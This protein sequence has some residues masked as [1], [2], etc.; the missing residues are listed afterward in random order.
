[1]TTPID[2]SEQSD[3]GRRRRPWIAL[4]SG[5]A[6][7]VGLS[8]LGDTP[9][10]RNAPDFVARYFGLHRNSVFAAVIVVTAAMI[11]M[12]SAEPEP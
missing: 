4:L 5:L 1:M 12:K 9:D 10:T 11:G 6:L 8:L 2:I 7:D 3:D